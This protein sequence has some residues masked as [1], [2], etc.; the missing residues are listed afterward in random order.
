MKGGKVEESRSR[1]IKEVEVN[2]DIS[3]KAWVKSH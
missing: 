2:V 1:T 3:A